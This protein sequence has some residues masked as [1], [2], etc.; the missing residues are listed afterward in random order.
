MIQSAI[1][2][3]ALARFHGHFSA[4]YISM[5]SNV[6]TG[7]DMNNDQFREEQRRIQD[8][9]RDEQRRMDEQRRADDLRRQ[10]MQR[11]EQRRLDEQ[12]RMDRR[13]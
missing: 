9:Q 13:Y 4:L 12:R 11:E 1:F 5:P 10:E 2:A 7:I 8:Q 6:K 3:E